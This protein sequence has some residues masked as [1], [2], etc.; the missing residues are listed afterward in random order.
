MA[1]PA[2]VAAVTAATSIASGGFVYAAKD[3]PFGLIASIC[4]VLAIVFAMLG[5]LAAD[6]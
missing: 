1:R 5:S 4:I 3:E 6:E 2:A